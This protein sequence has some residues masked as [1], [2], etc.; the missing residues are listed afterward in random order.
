MSDPL[1][2][3]VG[4]YDPQREQELFLRN[5]PLGPQAGEFLG[6]ALADMGFQITVYA[7][8]PHM[9]EVDVVRGY[10]DSPTAQPGSIHVHFSLK[11]GRPNFPQ[12][13]THPS[14]FQ[15]Y[16]NSS[17]D[18]EVSFYHSLAQV[19]GAIIL[20]GGPSTL[21]GGLVTIGHKKPILACAGFGG[22][23]SKVWDSLPTDS[24]LLTVEEKSLMTEERWTSELAEQL[25]QILK[26]QIDRDQEREAQ[27]KLAERDRIYQEVEKGRRNEK[28]INVHAI[29]SALVFLVSAAMWIMAWGLPD[30]SY[31]WLWIFLIGAPL[32][33]GIS[34]ATIR[35]VV[36]S[37]RGRTKI[38][39]LSLV[40]NAVL[41]L[42]SGGITAFLFILA[43]VFSNPAVLD[44]NV[45]SETLKRLLPFTLT[46]GFVA[47]LTLDVVY[48]RLQETNVVDTTSIQPGS[49]SS[50]D[51]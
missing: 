20:G 46:I 47:G 2:A 1:I 45:A 48:T 5:V 18:W 39:Q 44:Q 23:G 22:S 8:Y 19:D 41:G 42:V 35:V 40:R 14:L 31:L 24:G 49:G 13:A 7:S 30:L 37:R 50:T 16:P 3:I 15:F 36:D 28:N 25:V 29:V 6:K 17:E 32:L 10:C 27:L 34:G 38:R 21:I 12:E 43:Q 26:K 11:Y 33:T 51:E 4:S 9:L